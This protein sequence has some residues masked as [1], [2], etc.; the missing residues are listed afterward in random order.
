MIDD[1]HC[2]RSDPTRGFGVE[3]IEE[4]KTMNNE[5]VLPRARGGEE[6]GFKVI[7]DRHFTPLFQI[8][9]RYTGKLRRLKTNRGGT[10]NEALANRLRTIIDVLNGPLGRRRK[11]SLGRGIFVKIRRNSCRFIAQLSFVEG[12]T[13]EHFRLQQEPKKK[14]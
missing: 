3:R 11:E 7:Y 14:F 9:L 8:A 1:I 4:R 12:L 6:A 10:K 5:S 13:G 2:I